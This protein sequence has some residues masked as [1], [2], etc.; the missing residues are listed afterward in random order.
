MRK[1]FCWNV[2]KQCAVSWVFYFTLRSQS[3]EKLHRTHRHQGL[4]DAGENR[5][6]QGVNQDLVLGD[7]QHQQ[8]GGVL[9]AQVQE[10]RGE[11]STAANTRH[12]AIN[13]KQLVYVLRFYILMMF[14][15]LRGSGEDTG[16]LSNRLS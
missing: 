2:P 6:T 15:H 7:G 3:E 1:H 13:P 10:Q 14:S 9:G 4:R 12:T 16:W 11:A 5:R 8:S